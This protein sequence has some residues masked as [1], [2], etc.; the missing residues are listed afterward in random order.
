MFSIGVVTSMLSAYFCV[1]H[2]HEYY[3]NRCLELAQK[4]VGTAR[5]NPSVGCVVVC[6][7]KIIGEGYTSPYGGSHAEVNAIRSVVDK[8]LLQQATLY[9]TLEPCS[10]FG[11]TPPCADLIVKNKVPKVVIGCIDSH[12]KVAGKGIAR[13]RAAGCEV[14][15]GCLEAACKE[16][17]RR[18]F[19]VQNKKRPYIVLKWAETQDGFIAPET[20]EVNRP[21][22]ISN[23]YARQLVHKWR[24]EEHAILVGTNTAI[25]DNP[26]LD[27][28]KWGGNA[29]VRVLLDRALKVPVDYALY[30]GAVSTI[31]LTEHPEKAPAKKNVQYIGIEFSQDLAMQLCD[32]LFQCDI[33]SVFIEGGRQ[34]LQTFIDA[35]L[36]DE[37]RIFV[38]SISFGSG[39][40]APGLVGTPYKE[41][42][43]GDTLLRYYKNSHQ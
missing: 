6:N 20:K 15:V 7:D 27:V 16:Q 13:L 30:D 36:W 14:I 25:A 39:V 24:A 21:V 28:R 29:P 35:G 22:W 9:V 32:L 18:F 38:G 1:M 23:A 3:M 37:A 31:V 34:T 40:R 4:G 5:P 17:H 12:D 42:S 2:T 43:L 19:T 10:H 33:Q 26:K 41:V 11:K 8:N